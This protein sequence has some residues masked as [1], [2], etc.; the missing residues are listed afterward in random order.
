M[1]DPWC[2]CGPGTAPAASTASTGTGKGMGTALGQGTGEGWGHLASLLPTF[3]V[4]QCCLCPAV[5]T[6]RLRDCLSPLSV[7]VPRKEQDRTGLCSQPGT[8]SGCLS[9]PS[10]HGA[11]SSRTGRWGRSSPPGCSS[12]RT[13]WGTSSGSSAGMLQHRDVGAP[14]ARSCWG[15]SRRSRT[16]ARAAVVSQGTAPCGAGSPAEPFSVGGYC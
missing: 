16:G 13:H 2:C 7:R 6:R 9:K 4:G 1:L 15:R 5:D 10:R 12:P 11:G 3:S 8:G 14:T